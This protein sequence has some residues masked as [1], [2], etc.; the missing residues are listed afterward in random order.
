MEKKRDSLILLTVMI[1]TMMSAIDSTIVLLAL[2]DLSI[3]LNAGLSTSI[4]VILIYLLVTAVLTTQMGAIG[5]NFGRSAIFKIGIIIFSIASIICGLSFA[6]GPFSA[7]QVLIIMRG[8][9]AV[10]A[11]M[12]QATVSAIIA[13]TFSPEKR[14]K[15][16]GYTTL[17]WNI[18]GTLGIVLGGLITT[19]IGW[20]FIFLINGPIGL[21]DVILAVFYVNDKVKQRKSV[22]VPGVI[23]LAASLILISYGGVKITDLAPVNV[24]LEYVLSGFIFLALFIFIERRAKNPVIDLRAFRTKKISLSLSA[25]FLQAAGYLSVVFILILYLQG[26]RGYDPLIASLFLVPGYVI[27]SLIAPKM[28]AIIDRRGSESLATLG[29][30]LMMAGTAFYYFLGRAGDLSLEILISGSLVAGVGAAMFWP[31]NNKAVMNSAS[32]EIYGSISGLMRTLSNIGTI[33]S[34]I[35][36]LSIS[37]ISVSKNVAYAVFIGKINLSGPQSVDFLGGLKIALITSI[38]ILIVAGFFSFIRKTS[39]QISIQRNVEK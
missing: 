12:M 27:A 9:Q 20:R 38:S 21:L 3:S 8:V 24:V 30:I 25:T 36:A 31:A 1:G 15:A 23:S 26:V 18:G 28:G 4:W 35:L 16:F 37:A 19:L 11:A 6:V 34:F 17:G 39:R 10:G 13:D 2:P 7:I 22:D 32:R 33:V 14:G 29:I 5:D